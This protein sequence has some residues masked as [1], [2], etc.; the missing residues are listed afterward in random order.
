MYDR[1]RD[2]LLLV[3]LLFDFWPFRFKHLKNNIEMPIFYTLCAMKLVNVF[4]CV[5]YY[6]KEQWRR[7]IISFC[8]IWLPVL[9]LAFLALYTGKNT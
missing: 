4:L 3:I 7:K 6:Y 9:M 8:V 1:A 5:L 2:A